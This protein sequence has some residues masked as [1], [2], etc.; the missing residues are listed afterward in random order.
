VQKYNVELKITPN[1][2]TYATAS[3]GFRP[4]GA[5]LTPGIPASA[6][7]YAADSLWNYEMGVKTQFFNH[8]LTFNIDGYRIDWN[9]LQTSVQATY[10]NFSYIGNVGS[11][12]VEGVEVE[13]AAIPV[14]GLQLNASFNYLNPR[15]TSDQISAEVTAAGR[16][17]DILPLI[18]RV[19]AS[20][21]VEYDF[22]VYGEFNGLLRADYTYTGKMT[23]Q[24]RATNV[25][26]RE[27]GK[28]SQVNLRAGVQKDN[29]GAFIYVSNL[30][31]K[32]GV[33]TISSAAGVPDY[34]ATTRPRTIGLNVR[35]NF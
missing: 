3:Q 10:G 5:N 29:V 25:N 28:Y 13:A 2:M 26:Y 34:Y 18:P 23:S 20:A 21:G 8:R 24:I 4:G 11:A 27:F 17:G 33:N 1:I 30:F 14:H 6:Q 31:D 19:S 12:R 16:K 15:L 35:S 32:I 22:P 7:T 9:N